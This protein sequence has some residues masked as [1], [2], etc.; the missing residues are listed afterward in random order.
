MQHAI[1]AEN[2]NP[3]IAKLATIG[4]RIRQAVSQ[5]YQTSSNVYDG[6]ASY[7]NAN[8]FSQY[9]SRR[10]PLPGNLQQPPSLTNMGSTYQSSA[11]SSLAEWDSKYDIQNAPLQTLER[12]S[13]KLKRKHD[14]ENVQIHSNLSEY[15]N[16][17]G[18][19]SF[20]ETF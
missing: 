17:Y 3:D 14:D 12:D 4:M 7:N 10:V 11:G 5:G 20:N 16:K 13:S 6:T 2:D 18:S 1:A 8:N 19:L 9:D 15:E